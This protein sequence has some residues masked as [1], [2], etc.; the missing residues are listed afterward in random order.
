MSPWFAIRDVRRPGYRDEWTAFKGS[1]CAE[2]NLRH[3]AR[4]AL[5]RKI[6]AKWMVRIA[7]PHENSPQIGMVGKSD[8][9]HVVHFAF[10]PVCRG[11]DV[12]DGRYLKMILRN[13]SLQAQM[14]IR[15]E[16]VKFVHQLKSWFIAKIVDAGE[17]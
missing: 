2:G 1:W 4:F 16:R 5:Q 10:V 3:F 8:P 11:P 6:F 12:N 7:F 15:A 13:A 14:N 9:H 17:V